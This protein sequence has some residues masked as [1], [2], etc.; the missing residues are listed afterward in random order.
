[1][2]VYMSKKIMEKTELHKIRVNTV[3]KLYTLVLL[4]DGPKHGYE[5]MKLLENKLETKVGPS[6]VYPF[7]KQLEREGLLRFKELKERDKKVYSLTEEG[8]RFVKD[9]LERSIEFLQASIRAVG[10]NRVCPPSFKDN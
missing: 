5:L 2:M 1:M 4:F 9:L 10:P 7:L 8:K 6:Q 3:I